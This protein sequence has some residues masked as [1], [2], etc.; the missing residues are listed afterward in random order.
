MVAKSKDKN[1]NTNYK[2]YTD[3]NYCLIDDLGG[4][5]RVSMIIPTY[6]ESLNIKKLLDYIYD[7]DHTREYEKRN[8]D[9]NVLVVDDNSPDGTSEVVKEYQKKNSSVNLLVRQNKEGLGAAYIHGMSHALNTLH[10]HI[11]F[12]MDADLS[13]NPKYIV[14]MIDKIRE[15]ADFVIGSR[16]IKGGSI[17]DNWGFTRKATSRSANAYARTLLGFRDVHDCTGGYRAI[18]ASFLREIDLNSMNIKGYVFQI[19]L[20]NQVILHKG[21]IQE[22][23]IAFEDRTNGTSKMRIN[24]IMEVGM[25]VLR[26]AVRNTIMKISNSG[27][28]SPFSDKRMEIQRN[29]IR[30]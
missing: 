3:K 25:V 9:M 18:R 22:V 12:E 7:K 6:N 23:A 5:I 19:S 26:M 15:G 4:T 30:Y 16:Y 2:N 21:N 13:H 14:P 20:L 11:L 27:M 1:A 29:L 8:I 28:P 17:P 10:P 24:D